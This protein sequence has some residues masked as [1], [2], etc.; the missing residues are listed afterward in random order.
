[1]AVLGQMVQERGL[2]G[3]LY[4][5]M[6]GTDKYFTDEDMAPIQDHLNNLMSRNNRV[7][8]DEDL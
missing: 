1:M 6:Q 7:M 5:K 4:L 8:A 2:D 3:K